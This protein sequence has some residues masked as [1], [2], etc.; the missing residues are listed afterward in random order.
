MLNALLSPVRFVSFEAMEPSELAAAVAYAAACRGSGTAEVRRVALVRDGRPSAA[1]DALAAGLASRFDLVMLD[2]VR[3]DPLAADI[4][5]MSADCDLSSLDAVVGLGGG[6]V[7]DSA[8]ALAMLAANGGSLE[9]YLGPSP[10][11]KVEKRGLPLVLVPTTAGTGSE[12]TKVGVYTAASGR[13]YTLGSP[14][15]QADA[16]LLSGA[17]AASMPPAL[18]AS[19][20]FDALSHALESMWNRNATPLSLDAST[21][22][23]VLVLEAL[24]PAYEAAVEAAAGRK[25][26]SHNAISLAMLEAAAAAGVAFSGTGTALVHALSFVLSED[27]HV[28]HGTACAF[29]LE[30]AWRLQARDPAVAGRLEALA[31]E[32]LRRGGKPVPA[33]RAADLLLERVVAMKKRMGLPT[34]FSDL[35]I[36]LAK[37]DVRPRFARA[38]DDPKMANSFPAADPGAIYAMLEGKA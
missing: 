26:A 16:A 4:S 13:K 28:P 3:P 1:V 18:A 11:R 30:D 35:G 6:S 19:T 34:R 23:A 24:E 21:R 7:M 2:R 37:A 31:R 10:A 8:K 14:L 32:V 29:T 36:E 38:F 17:L 33:A 12:A 9:D 22:A 20:G 25:V 15:L 27:W 5:A